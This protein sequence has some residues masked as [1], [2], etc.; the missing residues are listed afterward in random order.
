VPGLIVLASPWLAENAA[1]QQPTPAQPADPPPAAPAPETA[2][3][4]AEATPETPPAEEEIVGEVGDLD[5]EVG[6]V[7]AAAPSGE[8]E[9]GEV[10]VTVDRRTKNLQ[11]YSGTASAFSEAQ[12]SNI[13]ITNV[14]DL[15]SQVPGLAIGNQEGNTEI[16]IRGIGSDNN[17]ELGDPAVALHLDGIY[18]PRPR[19]LGAMFFDIARVE[20]NSGPQG[21][22]RG[23]NA[24]GGSVNIVSNAPKLGEFEANAEATFG[25][26]AQRRYQGVVNIPLGDAF[27]FRAAAFSEVHD[28][29]WENA[30]PIYDIKG[31][32][33]ID[34]YAFRLSAK[35]QPVSAFSALVSFDYTR[36]RGT[37]WLGANFQGIFTRAVDVAGTPGDDSDDV[38]APLSPDDI[39]NPRR[40][41]NRGMQSW[42]DLKHWG[43]G[44]S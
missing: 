40:I 9:L 15:G 36:E 3:P 14:R 4:P 44:R 38:P 34:S 26:Y 39:D 35:W 5:L 22:L 11:K 41:Y 31:P 43:R 23:R 6:D 8:G 13:G 10:I 33:S 27:A 37:G 42:L 21:T 16:Y 29:W 12:L 2:P 19:G 32:E 20:V 17:T 7:D 18:L 1:A 30:G 25:T 24:L 28:P